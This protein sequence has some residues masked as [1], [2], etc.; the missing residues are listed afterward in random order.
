MGLIPPLLLSGS[1]EGGVESPS[2][3]SPLLPAPCPFSSSSI[4]HGDRLN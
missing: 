2:E 3:L 4:T 1:S